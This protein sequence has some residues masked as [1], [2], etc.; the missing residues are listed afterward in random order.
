MP[1]RNSS[2]AGCL[3]LLLLGALFSALGWIGDHAMLMLGLVVALIVAV[4]LV[5]QLERWSEHRALA[6]AEEK[7]RG[8][9]A[10]LEDATAQLV[11]KHSAALMRKRWQLLRVDDYGNA[12]PGKWLEEIRYFIHSN[13]WPTLDAKQIDTLLKEYE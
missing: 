8:D 4:V 5:R 3:V 11:E 10:V 1:R 9:R 2:G 13:L 12:I 6:M 7:A